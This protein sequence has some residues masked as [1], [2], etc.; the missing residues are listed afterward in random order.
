MIGRFGTARLTVAGLVS[1]AVAYLLFLPIGLDSSYAVMLPTF[2][3][4]GLGFGLAF[5]PINVAATTGVAPEEQ[6][7]AGG[8]VN[9]SFQL[10]AALVLR[11]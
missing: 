7:L 10:G 2:L 4:A 1:I 9:T 5:G 3:L 11:S 8:L 6:G